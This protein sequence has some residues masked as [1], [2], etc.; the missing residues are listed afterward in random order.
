MTEAMKSDN[1]DVKNALRMILGEVPRL[2]LKK[3]QQPTDE[4][5][6]S[7]IRKLIKS[8]TL[9]CEY[10]GKD[11]CDSKYLSILDSYMPKMMSRDEICSW[12]IKN[13]D[14]IDLSKFNPQVKAM[15]LIMKH[16]KGKADG[17]EVRSILEW[18]D[19]HKASCHI[20]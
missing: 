5:I 6:L 20:I 13:K 16:L 12:L 19:S 14:I 2:N 15:G 17:K 1:G 4:Q 18:N 10:S 3:D 7:I 9:V 11:V 8:E